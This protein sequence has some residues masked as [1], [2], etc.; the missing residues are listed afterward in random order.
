[1]RQNLDFVGVFTQH[2]SLK[3]VGF[4]LYNTDGIVE[5]MSASNNKSIISFL[6]KIF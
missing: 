4:I 1:M 6:N 3:E 5:D 2:K